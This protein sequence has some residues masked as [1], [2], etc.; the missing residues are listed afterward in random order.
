MIDLMQ[1]SLSRLFILST[2][3]EDLVNARSRTDHLTEI[4]SYKNEFLVF[5]DPSILEVIDLDWSLWLNHHKDDTISLLKLKFLLEEEIDYSLSSHIDV[6]LM[7]EDPKEWTE[8]SSD[9]LLN[10]WH[11]VN[12][13]FSQSLNQMKILAF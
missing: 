2:V 7:N 9:D 10:E 11:L 6:Q 8:I 12:Y 3:N 13:S 5:V 1:K 4:D